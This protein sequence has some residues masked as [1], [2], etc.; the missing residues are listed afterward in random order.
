MKT[1][2]GF[3][4]FNRVGGARTSRINQRRSDMQERLTAD[5]NVLYR[6]RMGQHEHLQLEYVQFFTERPLW[7]FSFET[8][9]GS[10]YNSFLKSL[11]GKLSQAEKLLGLPPSRVC[12]N[13]SR[14]ISNQCVKFFLLANTTQKSL[15]SVQMSLR[16]TSRKYC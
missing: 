5:M 1:N 3:D 13:V 8:A 16:N 2:G 15:E 12:A 9:L 4:F 7:H 14:N 6:N 10:S 11:T